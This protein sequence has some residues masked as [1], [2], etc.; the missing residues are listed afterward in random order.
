MDRRDIQ[1]RVTATGTLSALVTVQVGSQVSGRIQEI[2]VDFNSPVK[3]GQVIARIDPQLFQAAL[4]RARANVLAAQGQ[5]AE[6][7]GA[8][9]Q[10]PTASSGALQDA[11]RQAA[12]RPG[13][14]GHRRGH[15][16][17]RRRRSVDAAEAALAQAQALRSTRP[18]STSTTPPS[19]RP[20]TAS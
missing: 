1:S 12:H 11:A 15:R 3:K 17:G 4:E 19:S 2:T 13:R 16:R 10:T 5:P 7:P 8:G 20:W 18:R 9:A 14:A 6:G